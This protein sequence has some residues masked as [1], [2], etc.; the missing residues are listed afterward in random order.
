MTPTSWP[1]GRGRDFLSTRDLFPDALLLFER[2]VHDRV[3]EPVRC[4]D[5]DNPKLPR[6][7][8]KAAL[9]K[10]REEVEMAFGSALNNFGV[11][12]LMRGLAAARPSAATAAGR[13]EA[14]PAGEAARHRLLFR[15]Q[16]NIDPQH[17]DRIAY[18]RVCSG[19]FQRGMK[20]KNVRTGALCRCRP[21]LFPGP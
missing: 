13:A 1:I 10:L 5:F 7:L 3:V 17:R 20:L 12:E 21:G 2:G 16:A 11:R 18:V 9:A 14:D 4:S 19:R 15:V 8:P 6:L